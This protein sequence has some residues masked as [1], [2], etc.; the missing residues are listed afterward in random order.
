[1]SRYDDVLAVLKVVHEHESIHDPAKACNPCETVALA[2]AMN[3]DPQEVADRLSD[4]EKRGRMI[5][6]RKT[7]GDT[8]PYFVD[9]RLTANG[10]A[11]VTHQTSE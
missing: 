5:T 6:A 8:E 4:A 3:L 11:A 9:V 2:E 7:K 1:M 10:R